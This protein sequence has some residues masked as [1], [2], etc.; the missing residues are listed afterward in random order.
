MAYDADPSATHNPATGGTPTAAWGVILNANFAAIGAAPTSYS[1]AWTASSVNPAIGNGSIVG[2]YIQLGK[3]VFVDIA[4]V[5]GSTTTFGTG[6]Y[7]FSLPGGMTAMAGRTQH[8][9]AHGLDSGTAHRT[10]TAYV[11]A[12]ASVFEVA[13]NATLQWS[14]SVP[15]TWATSDEIHIHGFLWVA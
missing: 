1:P 11:A 5:M 13:S 7:S 3:L 14:P 2:A 10:G 6:T 8:I 4:I 9:L 15:H 12:G